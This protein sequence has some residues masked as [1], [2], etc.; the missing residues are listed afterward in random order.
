[1]KKIISIFL[2]LLMT[3][4]VTLPAYAIDDS[5]DILKDSVK[6]AER[7]GGRYYYNYLG[8]MR[9]G[10]AY[11]ELYD[12]LY[13]FA[14]RLIESDMDF[15]KE[16]ITIHF[17]ASS[18]IKWEYDSSALDYY[19]IL[20]VANLFCNENPYFYFM[21]FMITGDELKLSSNYSFEKADERK[22]TFRKIN[23]YLRSY[24]EAETYTDL[25]EKAKF[26]HDKLCLNMTYVHDLS[27]HNRLS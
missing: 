4:F 27:R 17:N 9:K 20:N 6:A 16:D 7:A 22:E 2:S 24:S 5:G 8:T 3:A 18:L 25:Y 21:N 1:M 23:D 13:D 15:G 14:L 19:E 12:K 10:A 11:Q 26:L